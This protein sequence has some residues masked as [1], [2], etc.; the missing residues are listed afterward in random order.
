MRTMLRTD[1]LTE[2]FEDLRGMIN[3]VAWR[4]YNRYGGDFEEWQAEA[5]YRFIVDY[6]NH[7][8]DKGKFTSWIYFC[9][10][11]SLLSYARKLYK[12][13]H[14]IVGDINTLGYMK[15]EVDSFSIIEILDEARGEDVRT[16]INLVLNPPQEIKTAHIKPGYHGCHMKVVLRIH[17]TKM[18]WTARRIKSSFKEIG[19]IING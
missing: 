10:W 12:Q 15:D 1:A 6:D 7:T 5:N 11:N 13:T 16:L 9:L 19:D 17:L 3:K 18:G 4:F 14:L 2:T 8:E